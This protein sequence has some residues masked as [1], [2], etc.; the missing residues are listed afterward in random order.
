MIQVGDKAPN[1]VLKN[2]DGIEVSLVDY[3][4]KWVII[5]IYPKDNTP[6]CTTQAC[7]FNDLFND[8]SSIDAVILGISPDN[9]KKH[10]NF[11]EKYNLNFT[12]LCDE[13]KITLKEYGAWGLKKLYG[14][15]YEGVIRSTFIINP[16]GKI[17]KIYSKV[18]A[19]GHA[20]IV[21]ED[22]KQLQE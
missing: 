3:S 4:G 22:L 6:G 11:I 21:K 9:E 5:Y 15:E 1:I 18:K 20:Q 16:D 7:E 10:T 19:K 2:Q 8:F 12:L 14:K 13:E 17:A